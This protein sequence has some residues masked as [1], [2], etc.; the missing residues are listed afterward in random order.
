MTY[1]TDAATTFEFGVVIPTRDLGDGTFITRWVDEDRGIWC[2][3][4]HDESGDCAGWISED[5]AL[6]AGLTVAS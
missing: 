3:V 6:E 2:W 5:T 4:E 1:N